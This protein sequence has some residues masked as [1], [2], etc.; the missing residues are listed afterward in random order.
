MKNLK[1]GEFGF[2]INKE[3]G[4]MNGYINLEK[5]IKEFISDDMLKE[6]DVSINNFLGK[7]SNNI[8]DAKIEE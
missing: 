7:L 4:S 1:I 3:E 8:K 5:G 2:E 6:L